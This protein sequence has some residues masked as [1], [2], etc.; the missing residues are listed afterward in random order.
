MIFTFINSTNGLINNTYT[1]AYH[2]MHMFPASS[3][4]W[5]NLGSIVWVKIILLNTFWLFSVYV[6]FIL[7]SFSGGVHSCGYS[8]TTRLRPRLVVAM[9]RQNVEIII[10]YVAY[11]A[12][13]AK[14]VEGL[15]SMVSNSER[16]CVVYFK[17]TCTR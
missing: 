3:M 8:H 13:T 14:T 6:M 1:Y 12:K 2:R 11:L 15:V 4:Q 5:Q 16:L 10:I 17:S 7:L 9:S